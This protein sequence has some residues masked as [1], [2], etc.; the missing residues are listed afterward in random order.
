[1]PRIKDSK[2]PAAAGAEMEEGRRPTI[3]SAPAAAA[4]ELLDRPRRRTFTAPKALGGFLHGRACPTQSHRRRAPVFYVP[5][6]APHRAHDILDDVRAG[7]RTPQFRRQS[8]LCYGEHLVE[9]FQDRGGNALPVLFEMPGK[10]AKKRLGLAGV[11][12]LPG[13]PQHAPHLCMHRFRQAVHDVACFMYLT[14][15]NG[16]VAS[17]SRSDR[18]GESLRAVD[19]E[20]A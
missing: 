11:G 14:A 19:D 10:V 17:E 8:E 1:M 7:E 6:D 18:L 9:P 15:L 12:Q 13:L 5:A 16:H 2:T 4:P 20:K 3:V